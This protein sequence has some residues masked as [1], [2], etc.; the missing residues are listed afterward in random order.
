MPDCTPA[1]WAMPDCKRCGMRKAPRG[2]SVP[3]EAANG[4]C[5]WDCPGYDEDPKPGHLWPEEADE[6]RDT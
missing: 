4:Y 3:L 6:Q 2:R 1:C 5:G